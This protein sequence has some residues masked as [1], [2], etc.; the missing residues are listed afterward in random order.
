MVNAVHAIIHDTPRV[1]HC[2]C[3]VDWDAD[4]VVICSKRD[5]RGEKTER[6]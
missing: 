6:A 1:V 2:V 5:E 4:S 3:V